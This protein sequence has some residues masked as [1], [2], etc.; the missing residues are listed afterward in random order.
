MNDEQLIWEAYE[1]SIEDPMN[2]V[3]FPD[4]K[5]QETV[6]EF[7]ERHDLT[8]EDGYIILYHG[9]PKKTKLTNSAIKAWS[10]FA[11]TPIE[12]L[13]YSTRDRGLKPS[14]VVV[15]KV[16]LSPQE[17][18]YS[19]FYQTN[20]DISLKE[21]ATL[22]KLTD[23]I[24]DYLID[25]GFVDNNNNTPEVNSNG[26]VTLYHNTKSE[27]AANTIIKTRDWKSKEGRQIF[28]STKPNLQTTGYGSVTLKVNVDPEEMVLDDVFDDE[29]H[30][31]VSSDNLKQYPVALI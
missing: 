21:R 19:G 31:W 25:N 28:F 9:T 16:R 29:L 13:H 23:I 2:R 3:M 20:K 22:L 7:I 24:K 10:Y 17:L 27:E 26:T 1:S 15:Y 8:L 14:S 4:S 6:G 5:K 18:E 11:K 30:V 12:S